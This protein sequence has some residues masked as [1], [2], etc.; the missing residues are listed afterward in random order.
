MKK[1]FIRAE[2]IAHKDL[3]AAGSYQQAKKDGKVR[4]EGKTYM[5][6]DGD[7]ITFHFNI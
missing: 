6:Q 3:M 2:V 4:L 1:G 5:V 7:V